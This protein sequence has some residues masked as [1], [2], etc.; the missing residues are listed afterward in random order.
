[1]AG[2]RIVAVGD[3]PGVAAARVIEANGLAVAPGF[4]D[5]HAHDD[6][7]VVRDGRVDFKVMQGVTTDVI[8]NCGAGVAPADD[9]FRRFYDFV[10]AGVLGPAGDLS[11]RTT[12]EYLEA[13]ERAG[14]SLN[15]VPLCPHGVLRFLAMGL[16]RRPPTNG[17]LEVMKALLAEAMEA[18]VAGLSTGLIYPPGAFAATEELVELA[19]VAARYGGLYV[20]HIR[21]EGL[22]LLEAVEEALRIGREAGL[23]VQISH[24][25]A[26][27]RA[28]W[29]QTAASLARIDAARADGQDVAVDVYPYVAGSTALI[30][31]TFPDFEGVPPED[32]LIASTK[33]NHDWEGRTLREVAVAMNLPPEEAAQ[34]LLREEE[35]AVVVIMF[36]M[37]EGDVRRVMRHPT[38]MF[39][40]DGIPSVE[41]KPH[42]RLYSTFAR[43][44]DRY[45]RQEG[46]LSL[47]EAVRK[48][49]SL[50]ARR[51]GLRERGEVRP[52]Y[53]ADLLLFEPAA[54]RDVA[55]FQEPRRYPEGIRHVIVNGQLVVE[56][57]RHTGASAGRVLRRG[58]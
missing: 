16:E 23:P 30:A 17:E 18:G 21:D 37:E 14:P 58:N 38:A 13:I 15:V 55:T 53:Y 9:A 51:F 25:K 35:G 49:T 34:R 47:E 4:I 3:A 40:S 46:V 29:G 33:H 6:A 12:A 48:M 10:L 45:V 50:P 20:S 39:G 19:K 7:A 26:F 11:W 24:H 2:E 52:G 32:V 42:P 36:G 27:G 1:M 8:G 54:V 44:L 28:V 5:V 43:V 22:H 57:G 41:G 31:V 56:E